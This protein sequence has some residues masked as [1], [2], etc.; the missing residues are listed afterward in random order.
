MS[1]S[2]RRCRRPCSDREWPEWCH[3]HRKKK[4]ADVD[5]TQ[6]G[7]D[8]VLRPV[9]HGSVEQV[10]P[11]GNSAFLERVLKYDEIAGAKNT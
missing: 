5:G 6:A 2:A 7:G 3:R 8:G 11:F 10:R 9:L 4:T 1:R